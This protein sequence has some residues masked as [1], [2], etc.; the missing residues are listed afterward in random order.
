M[1]REVKAAVLAFV[2]VALAGAWLVALFRFVVP[3]ILEA[4]FLGSVPAAVAAGVI[5]LVGL[6]WIAA[7]FLRAVRKL[8]S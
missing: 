4:H 3:A 1:D 5:G 6:V 7:R 8:I 2:G